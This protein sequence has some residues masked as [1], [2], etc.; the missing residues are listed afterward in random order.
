[1]NTPRNDWLEALQREYLRDFVKNGGAAVKFCVLPDEAGIE[2]VRE[3]LQ[4]SAQEEGY[5]FAFV[6]SSQTRVSQVDR[7]FFEVA[8]QIDWDGLAAA[9]VRGFF[10][11]N[12]YELP[13]SGELDL[14][15]VAQCNQSEEIYFR[16]RVIAGIENEIHHD[17]EMSQ[18][19]RL[20]MVHLCVS[21]LE[22]ESPDAFLSGAVKE[23][24]TG[25]LRLVS[26]LKGALIYQKITR[27]SARHLL[28]S[29]AHWL[30]LNGKSGLVVTLD[31]SR[32]LLQKSRQPEQE[33]VFYSGA[34][35][36]DAYEVLRQFIDGTDEMEGLM[37]VALAPMAFLTDEKRG[38]GRY[39]ALK[40][41]I[42]DDVRDRQ[43]QNP[44]ASMVRLVTP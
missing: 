14:R 26:A 13:P 37:I 12:K 22:P 40:M 42:W 4:R 10:V 2:S 1:M 36:L 8:R 15:S 38:L 11:R 39:D 33:G 44:L 6:D 29:L 16:K 32:L 27:H 25:E 20:A 19:F 34:A 43:R 5:S 41:R 3:P 7:I 31:I 24:L 17:Y 18:E 35:I 23:W 28:Y 9:F 30:R 21:R